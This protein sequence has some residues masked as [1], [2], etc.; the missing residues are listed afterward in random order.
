MDLWQILSA[1]TTPVVGIASI[2]I[3]RAIKKPSDAERAALLAR[4]ASDAAALVASQNPGLPWAA[5]LQDVMRQIR[6]VTG[7]P[8]TNAAA[9]ERAAAKALLDAGVR[10]A[11]GNSAPE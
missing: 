11:A 7:T 3:L 1:L 2:F 10:R 8:T 4:I 5:L 6:S 9:I